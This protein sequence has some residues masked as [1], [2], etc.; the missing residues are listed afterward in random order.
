MKLRRAGFTVVE[1]LVV[2]S[3]IA[4]LMALLLPA[5]QAARETSRRATCQNNLKQLAYGVTQYEVSKEYLPPSR[6]FPSMPSPYVRPDN[7]NSSGASDEY[8][9]WIH[10]IFPYIDQA[11]LHRAIDAEIVKDLNA[12]G[13]VILE[14][15]DTTDSVVDTLVWGRIRT[16]VCPSDQTNIQDVCRNSYASNAGRQDNTSPNSGIPMDWAANGVFD[17]RLKGR[18]NAPSPDS[19]PIN[20]TTTGDI[21]RGD[22][23]S[24]TLLLIEN[25]NLVVW[26]VMPTE[27]AAGVVWY[28]VATPNQPFNARR[29]FDA[30]ATDWDYAQ[31]TAQHPL[32][33]D[34]AMADGSTKFIAQNID[35]TVY[36]RLMTSNGGR[37]Q[38][39]G[40]NS[41]RP[42]PAYQGNPL[43]EDAF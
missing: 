24:T 14:D 1:L 27:Y 40:V 38:N 21:S 26:N 10:S 17:N 36:A 22:G 3:I 29:E 7:W 37:T 2:I 43:S 42:Q 4:V 19:F 8:I 30:T 18:P 33:F 11:D 6:A 23:T 31:P 12:G 16:L 9:S 25:V 32:G 34:V 28:P 35:Y 39:P 15:S 13:P 20:R 41:S 5:V